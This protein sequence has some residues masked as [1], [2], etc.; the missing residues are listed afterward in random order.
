MKQNKKLSVAITVFYFGFYL[1][2]GLL[3]LINQP[4]GDPRDE[5][6]RYLIPQYIVEH[7]SLPNGYEESIRIY[8][9]G[10]SYGFQPILPYMLMSGVM[11]LVRLFTRS[12]LALLYSAR[13]VNLVLGLIMAAIVLQLGKKWFRDRRLAWLFSFFVTFLPQSIFIHTY[14]NT[15]SCCMLS[16]AI[17]LYGL[18]LGI[19]DGFRPSTSLCMAVGIILCALSYYNAYGYIL[20][21]ILLFTVFFLT[22]KNGK[23]HFDTKGFFKKGLF[24]AAIVLLCI[25]WWFIRSAILYDGD[26]LGLRS[27]DECAALYAIPEFHPDTR[28]TWQSQGYSILDMLKISDFL[29]L[30]KLSF[31]AT[32]GHMSIQ[33]SVWVYYF[34]QYLIEFGLL[35]CI[36]V[37]LSKTDCIS[38]PDTERKGLRVFWHVNMIFCMLM[39]L[40]LSIYYSYSS[41][42]QPQGRYLLPAL[43]PLGYYC[44]H[45]WDKLL[46]LQKSKVVT[47]I[48]C[49][50]CTGIV[51]MLLWTVFRHAL[52]AYAAYTG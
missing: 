24:I 42:Y 12:E 2:I 17:M 50:I 22:L 36:L 29:Y 39:P 28:V 9:Y 16:I 45:G 7:G 33:T 20:S 27:R 49:L 37:P 13:M 26:F 35:L 30:S 31:I 41:D 23:L 21:C 10:F 4:F 51:C 11:M 14:V 40:I 48:V 8:G 38:I 25:S 46:N 1:F 32:Y 19:K 18:T 15:D 6:A 52:P 3:L 34:Y 44:I 5:Y 47:G 43:I